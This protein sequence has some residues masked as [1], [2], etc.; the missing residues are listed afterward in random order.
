LFPGHGP[1]GIGCGR[2]ILEMAYTEAL[3]KWR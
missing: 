3:L 2:K 1:A